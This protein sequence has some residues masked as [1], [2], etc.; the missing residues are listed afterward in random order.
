MRASTLLEYTKPSYNLQH[1]V[2]DS[3]V[4]LAFQVFTQM[5]YEQKSSANTRAISSASFLFLF[6]CALWTG[7]YSFLPSILKYPISS[8]IAYS[9]EHT[10]P[11]RSIVITP[12]IKSLTPR[13]SFQKMISHHSTFF[14][15]FF[16]PRPTNRTFSSSASTSWVHQHDTNS[17]NPT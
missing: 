5:V 12:I 14:P 7:S 15:K 9:R 8:S 10:E 17:N 1:S 11:L 13:E 16:E 4:D 3:A 6:G 2:S